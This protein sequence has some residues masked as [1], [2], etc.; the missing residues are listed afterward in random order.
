MTS[1]RRT[2]W[3]WIGMVIA[4][5]LLASLNGLHNQFAQDDLVLI[6]QNARV[7][8]LAN[9]RELIGAPF[10]PPP[11]SPN[12]YRP[13]TSLLLA[14][15]YAL[16]GG[17]P[18]VFRILSYLL[19]VAASI[20]VLAVAR[21]LLP[22]GIA[23]GVALLFAAHPVHVEAVALGVGQNELLVALCAA[24]ML[25]RYLDRRR[26]G[27][28][29]LGKGDWGLLGALY[30]AAALLKENG[31]ILPGL[32]LAAELLLVPG[33]RGAKARQLWPGYAVLGALGA[34]VLL[35]R[36][37][38]FPGHLAGS[39]VADAL[40]GQ[41]VAGRALT[42]LQVV[43]QWARLLAWPA[44]LQADYLPQELVASSG[45]GGA[46]LLGLGLLI[47]A[48]ATIW[49][50]RRRAPV[51]AFGLLWIA[52]ALLPVSNVVVPTGI[53]LAERTLFLPSLGF[54]LALGGL[55]AAIRPERGPASRV[56]RVGL[57]AGCVLL[58]LAGVLHSGR[59]HGV[60][61]DDS[62][63]AIRTAQE[64]P[65]SW[66]AQ[67]A[68]GYAYFQAGQAD[69]SLAG[70]QRAL[71]LA[72]KGE[73][74]QVRNDL[75]R[76]LFELDDSQLAVEQLRLSLATAPDRVETRHYLVLGLLTLGRYREAAAEADSAVAHGGG[77]ELFG[78]LRALAD[79]AQRAGAPPGSIRVRV[80]TGAVGTQPLP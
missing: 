76:R 47:G 6:A 19:Y 15:E 40:Q 53:L 11:Y 46:E 5:A 9:W 63:Y 62:T 3:L 35:V 65:R 69:A 67:K 59:R 12:L 25:I 32:L 42:M 34:L 54:G 13:L 73:V 60:W 49:L 39:F 74:W 30:L 78:G 36:S 37:A 21:R 71:E 70:Y 27:S 61:R 24:A 48:L 29:V 2:V 56:W 16:G 28:G 8:S 80:V 79:S 50:A 26:T 31:L 18:L 22:L 68:A 45:L 52:V 58:V 23:L 75:A 77:S 20:G 33:A 51:L 64:A 41:G 10:W 72:P 66:R 38:L 17:S 55:I 44:R 1:C 57:A 43:P 7:H 14:L 4:V